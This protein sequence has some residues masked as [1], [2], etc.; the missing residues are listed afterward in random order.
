MR[1]FKYQLEHVY[2]QELDLPAEA[3]IL[4]V[5][6]QHGK[7]QLWALVNPN[8]PLQER[9]FLV[10][11]TGHHIDRPP[12]DLSFLGSVIQ[13]DGSLVFHVFEVTK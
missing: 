7:I 9:K 11:G 4:S 12:Q 5:G 3:R 13:Y 2:D 6:D 8:A 10:A 1:I